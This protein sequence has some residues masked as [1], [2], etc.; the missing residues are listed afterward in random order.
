MAFGIYL[1]AYAQGPPQD[2]DCGGRSLGHYAHLMGETMLQETDAFIQELKQIIQAKKYSGHSLIQGLTQGEY[3]RENLKRW[4]IQEYFQV[5]QHIRAFG[6]IYANCPDSRVRR[7]LVENLID[8]ET[9]LRCG[10]DSHAM[11]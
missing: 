2:F 8:E 7:M 4:A 5:D 11:L 3:A 6:A 9:D 1:W 10:S